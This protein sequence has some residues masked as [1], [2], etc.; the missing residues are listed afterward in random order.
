MSFEFSILDF[1]EMQ[2]YSSEF[3]DAVVS[4][5]IQLALQLQFGAIENSFLSN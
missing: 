4:F 5:V 1:K 3:V 2:I